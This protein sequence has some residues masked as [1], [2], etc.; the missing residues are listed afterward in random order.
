ME[1]GSGGPVVRKLILAAVLVLVMLAQ[2]GGA[3]ATSKRT[4]WDPSVPPLRLT[5]FAKTIHASMVTV[6]C[7]DALGSGWAA[8]V[9]VTAGAAAQGYKSYV[10]T[11]HH[12]IGECTY[13]EQSRVNG[14]PARNG[15]LGPSVRVTVRAK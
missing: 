7:G 14:D 15:E 6:Y 4:T 12:V 5:D 9:G 10:V 1:E 13:A 2:V 8:Q 11:N 3:A